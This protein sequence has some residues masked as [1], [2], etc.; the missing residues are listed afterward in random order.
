MNRVI[1]LLSA[2][3]I[4]LFLAFDVTL[5]VD[6]QESMHTENPFSCEEILKLLEGKTDQ[7][8]IIEQLKR[9][10]TNCDLAANTEMLR[11][12]VIAGGS[13]EL[14]DAI[15]KYPYSDIFFTYPKNGAQVGAT[16]KVE[17]K[18][19]RI[20]GKYLWVFA[21]RE[22]LE[23]WWPQGGTVN[24]KENGEWR[25]GVFLG[26]PEDIGFD[27]E[28]K[29]QWVDEK[30]NRQLKDYLAKG[31]ATRHYPG[32]VLPDGAPVAKLIVHKLRH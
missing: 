23:V 25:Q 6:A 16:I 7:S 15:K 24:V 17:G 10:R 14:L 12:I 13:V 19:T 26:K 11:E 5:R 21:H 22:G 30:V 31:E 27:F 4:L 9:F 18:S 1:C 20:N 28:I 32:I 3:L 8:R 2:I 29:A